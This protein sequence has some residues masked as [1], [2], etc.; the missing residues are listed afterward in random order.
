MKR[1]AGPIL[2]ID[3][4]KD[5]CDLL[6]LVLEN[7]GYQVIVAADGLS[8]WQQLRAGLLPGL[9]ILDWMMPRMDGEQFLKTVN[10]NRSLAKVPVLVMSGNDAIQNGRPEKNLRRYLK[11]PVELDELLQV[12]AQLLAESPKQEAA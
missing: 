2:L 1:N 3:D 5:I 8:A 11:K 6:R 7:E 9:M 4:D 12:V 10:C